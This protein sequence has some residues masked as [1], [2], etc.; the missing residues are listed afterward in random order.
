MKYVTIILLVIFLN[1]CVPLSIVPKIE[2][3]KVLKAKKFKRKLP[4]Q[5]MFVFH[6]PKKVDEFYQFIDT[7]FGFD[8]QLLNGYVPFNINET[9]YFLAFYEI[10]RETKT[11]NLAPVLIDVKRISK[12]PL[13]EKFYT[14]RTG[15]WYIVIKV[16]I[17]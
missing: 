9:N 1:S 16:R 5:Y 11:L 17:A 12:E 14:S 15:K 4:N 10:E 3:F 13:L 8:N 6:D 7:K 2:D